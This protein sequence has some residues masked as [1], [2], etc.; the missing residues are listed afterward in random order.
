MIKITTIALLSTLPLISSASDMDLNYPV[1]KQQI[2]V[3]DHF[4]GAKEPKV[5]DA[6][7]T[8]EHA[9]KVAMYDE[10]ANYNDYAK[11]VCQVLRN[12]GFQDEA[13]RVDVVSIDQPTI[14]KRWASIG[15]AKCSEQL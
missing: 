6:L 13:V 4:I 15:T 1:N 9:F 7:W 5:L 11:Y 14:N 10:G 8:D 2:L 12:N 3:E